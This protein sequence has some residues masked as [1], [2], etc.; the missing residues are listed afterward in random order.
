M[1]AQRFVGVRVVKTV[2]DNLVVFPHSCILQGTGD[3]P[4]SASD[5][6]YSSAQPMKIQRAKALESSSTFV[7]INFPL[8]SRFLKRAAT[9]AF[10]VQ[11]YIC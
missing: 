5:A 1:L 11:Y 2:P 8:A 10:E 7:L 3:G 6:Y 9:S 4:M